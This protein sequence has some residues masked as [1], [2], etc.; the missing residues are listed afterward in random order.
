MHTP[1]DPLSPDELRAAWRAEARATSSFR[2]EVWG[3]IDTLR[4]ATPTL[5]RFLRAHAL[6]CGAGLVA[7][8]VLPALAGHVLAERRGL[9]EERA[10]LQRYLDSLDPSA[11]FAQTSG[12]R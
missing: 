2:A 6:A 3:R 12:N 5:W 1:Q 9:A 8:L 7:A 4:A 11:H 10:N